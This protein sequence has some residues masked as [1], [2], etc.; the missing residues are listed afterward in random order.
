MLSKIEITCETDKVDIVGNKNSQTVIPAN[1]SQ[2]VRSFTF[3]KLKNSFVG[4][5]CNN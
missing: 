1:F 5:I 4:C 3:R 2:F